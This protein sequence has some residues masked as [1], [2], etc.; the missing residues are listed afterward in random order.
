MLYLIS[1]ASNYEKKAFALAYLDSDL[2]SYV[3]IFEYIYIYITQMFP[4]VSRNI[5]RKY[6]FS[7][8]ETK[9]K[10]PLKLLRIFFALMLDI[11]HL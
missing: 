2:V 4:L 9:N 11:S 5:F 3:Y 6:K 1:I 7:N 10:I 8:N